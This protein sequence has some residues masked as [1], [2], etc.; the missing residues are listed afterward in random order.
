MNTEDHKPQ[1][2]RAAF[3]SEELESPE[4]TD[5]DD[6]RHSRVFETLSFELRG[7]K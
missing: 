7:T 6:V 5:L 2:A 4:D 3:F 1:K